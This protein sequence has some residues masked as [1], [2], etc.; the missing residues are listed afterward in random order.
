MPA[1]RPF[2]PADLENI[3]RQSLNRINGGMPMLPPAG[4]PNSQLALLEAVQHLS[5]STRA[6]SSA[7][8]ALSLQELERLPLVLLGQRHASHFP[9][10]L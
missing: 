3:S 7:V 5:Q 2:S 1:L 6:P 4:V 9:P 10:S 8:I